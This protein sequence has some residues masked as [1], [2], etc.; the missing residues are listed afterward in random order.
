LARSRKLPNVD[1]YRD[2]TKKEDKII[3]SIEPNPTRYLKL[4][5]LSLEGVGQQYAKQVSGEVRVVL[6]KEL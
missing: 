5:L 2:I 4:D 6:G 3:Y 1:K